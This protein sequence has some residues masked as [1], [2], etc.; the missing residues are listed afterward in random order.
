M[1]CYKQRTRIRR[2]HSALKPAY[3]DSAALASS[4]FCCRVEIDLRISFCAVAESFRTTK[5]K[6]I[7]Q[8]MA[9]RAGLRRAVFESIENRCH[10]RRLHSTPGYLSQLVRSC[11]PQRRRSDGN[12]NTR[13][14]SVEPDQLHEPTSVDQSAVF[15]THRPDAMVHLQR[16]LIQ[17]G[18]FNMANPARS[19]ARLMVAFFLSAG[20]AGISLIVPSFGSN[21]GASSPA[22]SVDT[23]PTSNGPTVITA[24]SV[25]PPTTSI[26][27]PSKGATLS[28]TAATL[29][30]SASNATSVQ[31]LLFGGTYGLSGHVV[32]TASATIYGWVESWNTTTVPDGSYALFS[33][34]SGPGGSAVSSGV[35]ITVGNRKPTTSILIPSKGATLSGTAATLDAS[36]SNATSVQFLLFGGTYG[37]SGHVVGTAS[38]TIYGWVES[39]NTTTVPDGSYALFSDASGPGGSAV[40]SGVNITVDNGSAPRFATSVSASH[41]YLVD[42]YGNPF[43]V[44]GD[45]AWNLAWGLDSAD[46]ATYLADRQADGFNT[47]VTDLVGPATSISDSSGANYNGDVP[48]TGGNFSTPNPAYWSKIDTFFHSAETHGITVFAIPID[49]YATLGSNVF[50]KMTNA[51]AKTF[52]QWLANRYPSSNYPGIVWML[53]NDY[54]GDGVGCCNGGFLSQYQAFASGLGTARLVTIEQGADESLSTDGA[55]LGP[56]VNVNA[57]YSY[58]PTYE[59]IE[60]GRTTK[61]IPVVFFEGA[62][63]NAVTGHPSTP[64]DLRKQLGWSMTSGGAGTFYGNDKLWEFQPAW[65]NQ[66]DTSGVVQRKALN[67]AFAGVNW[68]NLH[69][70]VNSQ[71]VVSGRNSEFTNW[72]TGN[73]PD[74]NDPTYG[75]YVSAA[76]STDGALGMI[77]NPDTTKNRITISSSVLGAN[78]S[79]TAVD[80]TDGARTS[81]GWTTTPTMGTNA[82]GDHDWLFIITASPKA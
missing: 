65:Q 25:P 28:G 79:I 5:R 21:A 20:L 59:V 74:T 66:L 10:T 35:N 77:Y 61:S 69:P 12:V 63:E 30:A 36:A 8:S 29:D 76:Y 38:A 43:L 47:I 82:G 3:R 6:L 54:A 50:N 22:A 34:A 52:G 15:D 78:P 72:S 32:G 67:A 41:T 46:Q 1:L 27:I 33:D 17:G 45:S 62:Y 44:N 53:G 24:A 14:L 9:T 18:N 49:A 56:L 73:G 71:L 48:F 4:E 80:P 11:P 64:L 23:D 26:L 31:F 16:R 81:L 60:R 68:Q 58:H 75:N 37:L 19:G 55:T 2:A 7:D 57:G 13:N 51:Q 42:Q 40:S 39:W 70:D